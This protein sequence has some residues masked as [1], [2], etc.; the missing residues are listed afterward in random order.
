[1]PFGGVEIPFSP[2]L[3][4]FQSHVSLIV[5]FVVEVLGAF[6]RVAA[7]VVLDAPSRNLNCNNLE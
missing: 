5:D 6:H 2:S 1:M 7:G 4:D 3:V